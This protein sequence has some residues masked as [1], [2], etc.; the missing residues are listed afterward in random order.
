MRRGVRGTN[1][2]L[3]MWVHSNELE[4]PR[5]G[6][7]VGRKHGSAVVRNRLKRVMRAAFRLSQHELP[8]GFDL[9]CTPRLNATLNEPECRAALIS[10][11]RKLVRRVRRP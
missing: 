3:T 8:A 10:L 1:Q 2:H 9:I 7:I 6:L 11:A 4:H 5:L